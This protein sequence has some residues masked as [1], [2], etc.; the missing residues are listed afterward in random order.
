MSKKRNDKKHSAINSK[1]D[2]LPLAKKIISFSEKD[3]FLVLGPHY[4]KESKEFVINAYLPIAVKARIKFKN[5]KQ[6]LSDIEM[7][8][9]LDE[10]FFQA[11]IEGILEIKPYTVITEDA[12]GNITETEDPYC[13]P[14]ELSDLDLYKLKEG[15]DFSC[16]DKLGSH[17]IKMNG[18]S[19]V[20][21][22]VWAPNAKS[23]SVMCEKNGWTKGIHPMMRFKNSDVWGLFI[24]GMKNGDV[25]KYAIMAKSDNQIRIKSDPYA[26]YSELRPSNASIVYTLKKYKW[27][28]KEWLT[29]R[30]K[31]NIARSPISI[32]EVH[33]GSWQ[34]DFNNADF[35]N[36]WGYKSYTQIAYEL[37]KYV[38][39]MGY[40]HIELMPVMEHPLDKSWGYQVVNYFAPSSRFG[41]PEELMFLIDHCHQNNIGVI[42]DWVPGHF[43]S[44]A[45]GLAD[46]DGKEIYA[47]TDPKKGFH[48]GW[49]TYVFDYSKNEIRNF[50]ISN[51]IFWFRKYHIDG[52]R[53]DAVASMLYLDYSRNEGEWIPNI[54]GGRE[55]IEAVEFL[56]KLNEKVHEQ[57]KGVMMIAEES[58][59]WPGTT[60]PVHIGGL[61]FDMRW[62]MG[63]MHDVLEYFSKDPIHRKFIHSKI[64]FS[65]WYSFNENNLLPISHDEVVHLKKSLLGKMPGDSWQ[66]FANMRLF[67]GFMF[68]HPGK[69]L[70]FMTND[71]GQ[72]TEWNEDESIKWDVLDLEANRQLKVYFK[73]LQTLYLKQKALHEV[74]FTSDGFHW[75]DFTDADNGVLAFARR[76][77][78]KKE[79]IVFTM[80]LTPVFRSE[81]EF[82]VPRHGFYKEIMNSDAAEYGG[83]GK[84]NLGGVHT[85]DRFKFQ[86]PYTIKVVLPPLGVNIFLY[87]EGI[88]EI[89]T[90]NIPEPNSESIIEAIESKE[91]QQ[92]SNIPETPDPQTHKLDENMVEENMF[93]ENIADEINSDDNLETNESPEV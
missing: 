45:H 80:N 70:N 20:M 52:M 62:N 46:F 82:G 92:E 11:A 23:A 8:K 79:M 15:N 75:L 58:T 88:P 19:G 89:K 3:P 61:G 37:V 93:K 13:Y 16:Q 56:R 53:V 28:D 68:G 10:G 27:N 84:G 78:D 50:L 22:T 24:P 44:D 12:E 51:A 38:K 47:Y 66:M 40:T 83:S 33:L 9:I 26:L 17:V 34:K 90:G 39:E 64:T 81:Y 86:W 29:S 41:K 59:S 7:T 76:S 60:K 87:E 18:V 42:F 5:K 36:E 85:E 74:D 4:I 55:N 49:G 14:P 67:F 21:F 31:F 32:Y 63:W 35:P 73:D 2:I 54:Y 91:D 71:I 6:F 65:L 25:Y 43:P 77:A 1:K 30:K 48:K 57:F 72:Y 69:K